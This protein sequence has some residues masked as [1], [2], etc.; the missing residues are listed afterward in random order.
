MSDRLNGI[1]AFVE[2]AEAGSFAL[3]AERMRLTRS[4]VGKSIARLEQRLGVRLF[5]RTTRSQSL[6]EEG[7]AYYERCVRALAELSAGALALDSGKGEPI[8][9]LRV[10]VP[11]LFGRHCAAPVLRALAHQFPRLDIEISFNDQT[12]DLVDEGYDLAIRI[13]SLPDSSTLVARRLSSQRMVIC[14]APSYLAKYGKPGSADE[15]SQHV[16]IAYG[17]SGRVKPWLMRDSAGQIQK[18]QIDIRLMFDDLQAITDA[19][20]AGAGL[21]WL[22]CWLMAKH[23][24]AGEL[25]LVMND[26]MLEVEIYAV[27]PKSHYLPTKTRVAIDALVAEIPGMI[28]HL[29]HVC[30]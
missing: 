9:R 14:A 8:G 16:G 3:A 7:Q 10:S 17:R 1:S 12:V 4:S 6:T 30:E 22:P 5:Q 23:S 26:N 28:G 15:L 20:I 19:A 25:E 29:E 18:P 21:A 24:R 2:A 11:V 27:W 13:G